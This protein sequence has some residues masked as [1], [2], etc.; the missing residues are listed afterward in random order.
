[1]VG[2]TSATMLSGHPSP[3]APAF[4]ELVPP[5]LVPARDSLG[6]GTSFL[7][8]HPPLPSPPS[9]LSF[10]VR[11]KNNGFSFDRPASAGEGRLNWK[12]VIR[13]CV[14]SSDFFAISSSSS[15]FS[16]LPLPSSPGRNPLLLIR[17]RRRRPEQSF[18]LARLA[19][20]YRP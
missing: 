17:R 4:S 20:K 1:M 10:F 8:H 13:Q 2:S 12:Y 15:P 9:S 5:H 7:P 6:A 3:P 16:S 14:K 18:L 11:G 19:M